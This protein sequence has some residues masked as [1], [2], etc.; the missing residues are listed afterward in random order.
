MAESSNQSGNGAPRDATYWAQPVSKLKVSETPPD[1]VNLNVEGRQ[2]VG[3]LQGFGQMWQKTY[4]VRLNGANVTPA[5]VV[6]VWK[7]HLPQLMPP[8]S[9][10]YPSLAG[11][12]PGEVVLINAT[13]AGMPV[14]TGVMILYADDVSFTVMT[15]EGHPESGFNTFSAYEEDGSVIAQVQ[16]LA[17]ANDPIYEF[18]F[19]FMGGSKVQERIWHHVLT[20]LAAQFGAQVPVEMQKAC[21]DPRLQW[22]QA[23]NVWQ[24]AQIRTVIYMMATPVRWIRGVGR[25]RA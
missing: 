25:R 24:N 18:G 16:S 3:P 4:R 8:D 13:V 23:K 2:V 1:A 7:A 6:A 15:P 20:S 9:R 21:V 19:R 11:V 14:S 22:R 5:Q 12:R 10:F 17:R